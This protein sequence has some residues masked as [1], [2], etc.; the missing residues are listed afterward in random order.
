MRRG[1]IVCVVIMLLAGAV[2]GACGG[3]DNGSTATD[4]DYVDA[5]VDGLLADP[6]APDTISEDDARCIAEAIVDVYGA[7]DFEEAD[8]SV[9]DVKDPD[10][11]LSALP[12]PSKEQAR[13]IGEGV[14][15]CKVGDSFAPLFIEGFGADKAAE[16]CIAKRLD[17]DKDVAPLLGTSIITDD[18]ISQAD[19]AVLV[20]VLAE[21][22]DL[23][24]IV[25]KEFGLPLTDVELA[26]LDKEL[27]GSEVFR[28]YVARQIAGEK[29]NEDDLGAATGTAITKCM[30]P[31]RL[32][33]LGF[34]ESG[35]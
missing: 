20:D 9:S 18:E 29:V 21:C 30:T 16:P 27:E 23:G 28:Q 12:G 34:T 14:Q 6:N 35:G 4:Q 26:C 32:K 24:A 10:S 3:D 17:D 25:V 5:L 2:L 11:D 33:E 1:V 8:L 31:E 19:A 15:A 13:S 7:G 22:I